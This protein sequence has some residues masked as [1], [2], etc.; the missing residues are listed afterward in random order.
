MELS[1]YSSNTMP[2]A[3]RRSSW[4]PLAASEKVADLTGCLAAVRRDLAI[5]EL[6]RNAP[7]IFVTGMYAGMDTSEYTWKDFFTPTEVEIIEQCAGYTQFYTFLHFMLLLFP[8]QK[9]AKVQ[10]HAIKLWNQIMI[11]RGE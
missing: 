7:E 1:E 4:I 8:E 3:T 9:K 6:L 2:T 11:N 10:H 5:R